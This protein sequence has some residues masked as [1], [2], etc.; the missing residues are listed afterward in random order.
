VIYSA[1]LHCGTILTYEW[2]TFV[3]TT[4][5]VV[6]CRNHG[7]C[8][9]NARGRIPRRGGSAIPLLRRSPR[10]RHELVAYLRAHPVTTVHALRRERFTLRL[11]AAVER[12]GLV[13]VDL[14]S[15][16]VRLRSAA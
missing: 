9:V 2:P 12:E 7:Y 14:G 3:P 5:E 8:R 15:G 10:S 6:P 4:G 11:V 1:T 16:S 13:E